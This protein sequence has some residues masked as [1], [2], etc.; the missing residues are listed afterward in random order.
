MKLLLRLGSD[1][2]PLEFGGTIPLATMTEIWWKELCSNAARL[3]ALDSLSVVTG[4]ILLLEMALFGLNRTTFVNGTLLRLY[5]TE[6]G[7]T[8]L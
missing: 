4:E 1:I 8:K 3:S 5:I 2:L 6:Y 7:Y